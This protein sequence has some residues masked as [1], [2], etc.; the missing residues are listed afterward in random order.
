MNTEHLADLT[1]E[2]PQFVDKI[3]SLEKKLS[4]LGQSFFKSTSLMCHP[5]FVFRHYEE[6]MPVAQAFCGLNENARKIFMDD[7]DLHPFPES[8][9]SNPS[10]DEEQDQIM[11]NAMANSLSL[12]R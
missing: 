7:P 8:P 5:I 4:R 3:P 1:F 11:Q 6:F 10:A 9:E 2:G 12:L